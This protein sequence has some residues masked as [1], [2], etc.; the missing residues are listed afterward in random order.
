MVFLHNVQIGYLILYYLHVSKL[1][2]EIHHS[3]AVC[4]VVFSLCVCARVFE[5]QL[6][7]TDNGIL[8]IDLG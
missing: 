3:S 5:L 6:R 4:C 8:S 2:N 7:K 1:V